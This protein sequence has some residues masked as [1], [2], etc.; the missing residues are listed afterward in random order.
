MRFAFARGAGTSPPTFTS[1]STPRCQNVTQP[2]SDEFDPPYEFAL[3]P[4]IR[5]SP[6]STAESRA[7]ASVD[8]APAMIAT[9]GCAPAG[10]SIFPLQMHL[11]S[12]GS[13]T[14]ERETILPP[15]TAVMSESGTAEQMFGTAA[16]AVGVAA[17][18][19]TH[20][21]SQ[22]TMRRLSAAEAD[23]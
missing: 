15:S 4:L 21:R 3:T 6:C 16:D 7:C 23:T 17:R 5:W 12:A 8:P 20:A 11:R 10:P 9:W 2:P 14:E 13:P 22:R 19:T 18:T 1:T